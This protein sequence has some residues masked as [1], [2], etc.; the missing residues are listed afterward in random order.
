[1]QKAEQLDAVEKTAQR[2][3]NSETLTVRPPEDVKRMMAKAIREAGQNPSFWIF[4][5]VRA[6]LAKFAGKRD[7]LPSDYF[8]Q[9]TK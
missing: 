1:M 5:C 8:T 2:V 4:E 3:E 7:S 6:G 9:N